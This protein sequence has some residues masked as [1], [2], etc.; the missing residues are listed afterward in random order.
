MNDNAA[1][2]EVTE[3]L[4]SEIVRRLTEVGN[5]HK[6]V[7]FGSR[8][9]GDAHPAGDLDILI[10]EDS[11]LPRYKRAPGYRRALRGTFPSKDIPVWTPEEVE[12]WRNVPHAFITVALNEGRV[13]YER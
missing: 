9:R 10:I 2:P 4:L 5:P 7:L 6:I 11:K 3:E 1:F 12:E 8:A 13:L